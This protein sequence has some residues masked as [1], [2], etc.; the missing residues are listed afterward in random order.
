MLNTELIAAK[1]S[2]SPNR[3]LAMVRCHNDWFMN[4]TN[5]SRGVEVDERSGRPSTPVT[6]NV[7][8]LKRI[9]IKSSYH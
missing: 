5:T 3:R 9:V 4:G 1:Y 7:F 2:K 6:D 8:F